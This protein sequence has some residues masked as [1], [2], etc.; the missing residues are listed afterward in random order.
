MTTD[1]NVIQMI[2]LKIG[3]I[4][5]MLSHMTTADVIKFRE[6]CSRIQNLEG[7]TEDDLAELDKI[8]NKFGEE[9]NAP[10]VSEA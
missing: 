9:Q 4:R 10:K 1:D 7:L 6:I 3:F 2:V 5:S 8:Y